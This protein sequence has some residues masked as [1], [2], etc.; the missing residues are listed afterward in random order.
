MPTDSKV[1]ITVFDITGA[2]VKVLVDG[3]YA[4]IDQSSLTGESLPVDKN[5]SDVAYSGSEVRQGEMNG[6]VVNTGEN[7]YFGKSVNQL[8]NE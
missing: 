8:Y 7:T 6:L 5:K 2:V 1:K 4:S 3:D